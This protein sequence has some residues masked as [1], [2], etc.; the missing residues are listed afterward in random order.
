MPRLLKIAVVALAVGVASIVAWTVFAHNDSPDPAEW[1]PTSQPVYTRQFATSQ[2]R[3]AFSLLHVVREQD[4]TANTFVSPLSIRYALGMVYNGAGG[5]TKTAMAAALQLDDPVPTALNIDNVSLVRG[6][7][8]SGPEVDF[9]LRNCLI[10][11]E[12]VRADHAFRAAYDKYYGW[13][14]VPMDL[15][16]PQSVGWINNWVR[17]NTRG[18]ITRIVERL[19]PLDVMVLLNAAYLDA[20]WDCPF[21]ARTTRPAEFTLLSGEVEAVQMMRHDHESFPYFE[22]KVAR[23]LSLP[24]AG[25]RLSMIVVLPHPELDFGEFCQSF[26]ANMWEDMAAQMCDQELKVG[27][28]RFTA[29]QHLDLEPPLTSLGMGVAFG[30]GDAEFPSLID[31]DLPVWISQARH[32]ATLRVD[33]EGTVAAAASMMGAAMGGGGM[34]APTTPFIVDRPFIC[35]IRDNQTGAILFLG[36]IVSPEGA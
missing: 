34:P 32:A 19:D 10:V 21:E 29:E 26:D 17:D 2:A 35:G 14:F 27:L 15:Q 23:A 31:T 28:P 16:A 20:K 4:P 8:E 30:R 3:F 1:R 22:N 9:S 13:G 7:R 18:R 11:D 5:A 36:A 6:L 25:E 33:E 12:S 24:Y